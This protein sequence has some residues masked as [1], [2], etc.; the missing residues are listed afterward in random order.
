L[1]EE[2]Y[3]GKRFRHYDRQ[4]KGNNDLLVL[5]QPEIIW[6]IH[7]QY[8]AAGADIVETNTF[9]ANAISQA[10]YGLEAL[11]YELNVAAAKIA[12]KAV[13]QWNQRTPDKPRFV[14]GAMGPT[15]K[16]LSLSPDVARPAYRE[17]PVMISGT[18]V[19]ASG[20]TLSGQTVEAFWISVQHTPN[21]L[22]VGLNCALGSA[23]MRPFIEELSAIA[24]GIAR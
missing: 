1:D 23:Q 4:L 16:T 24:R 22:S 10:D 2:D 13:D 19:D 9:N 14:A 18:V 8:L 15:N 17:V 3:R 21:L 7:Q 12:R 11:C 5:T 6:E 20:R